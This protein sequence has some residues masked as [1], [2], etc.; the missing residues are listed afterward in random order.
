MSTRGKVNKSRRKDAPTQKGGLLPGMGDAESRR[1]GFVIYSYLKVV[2]LQQ[3]K[4]V[5]SS[6]IFMF[7][8]VSFVNSR[9]YTKGVPFLSK[10]E[11]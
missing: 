2:H 8:G 3:L 10:T 9:Y 7:K 6:K 5:Q 1:S 4:D 11:V